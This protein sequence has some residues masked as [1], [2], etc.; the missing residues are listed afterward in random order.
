MSELGKEVIVICENEII[1]RGT[2]SKHEYT[3]GLIERKHTIEIEEPG[4][5]QIRREAIKKQDIREIVREELENIEF[6]GKIV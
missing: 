4:I 5:E 3:V 6:T 2:I 1:C